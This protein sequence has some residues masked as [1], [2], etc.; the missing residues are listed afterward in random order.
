MADVAGGRESGVTRIFTKLHNLTESGNFYE[1]HQL[2]RTIYFRYIVMDELMK[3]LIF[4][5]LLGY[6]Y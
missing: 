5:H 6:V 4:W 3:I 2:Y 1:A